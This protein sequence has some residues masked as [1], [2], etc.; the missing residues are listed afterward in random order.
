M[1]LVNSCQ[2]MVDLLGVIRDMQ[3]FL[4]GVLV[5]TSLADLPVAKHHNLAV[6]PT[7]ESPFLIAELVSWKKYD[8]D[9]TCVHRHVELAK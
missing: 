7:E 4:C 2:H 5:H 8:H 1:N 9:G 3:L 6:P